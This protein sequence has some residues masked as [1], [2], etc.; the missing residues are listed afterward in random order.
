M[1][2]ERPAHRLTVLDVVWLALLLQ[3]GFLLILRGNVAFAA[4][5]VLV[6]LRFRSDRAW[7]LV[8]IIAEGVALLSILAQTLASRPGDGPALLRPLVTSGL[9]LFCYVVGYVRMGPHEEER[10][11]RG[12]SGLG[13][14]FDK[15]AGR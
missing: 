9:F 14:H 11:Q 3:A 1:D 5:L 13:W 12:N 6:A 4:I 8:P 7:L 15:W 10:P 2:A